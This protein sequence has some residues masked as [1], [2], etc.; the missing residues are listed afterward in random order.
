MKIFYEL[1]QIV[2]VTLDNYEP[3]AH[4]EDDERG[5]A[6]H[7]WVDEV[8]RSE[9]RDVGNENRPGYL[10]RKRPE[11]KDISLLTRLVSL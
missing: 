2:H 5:E 8:I 4:N 10:I 6:H 9:G 11:K 7:N 1:L 3:D